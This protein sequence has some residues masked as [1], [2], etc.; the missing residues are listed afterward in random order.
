ML[1]DGQVV[2]MENEFGCHNRLA[3]HLTKKILEVVENTQ[4]SV[5]TITKL[6]NLEK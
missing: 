6:T 1:S 4:I 2:C 5:N 3:W